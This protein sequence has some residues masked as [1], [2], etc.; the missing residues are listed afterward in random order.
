MLPSH[1]VI[2]MIMQP[3]LIGII[4]DEVV[5]L[6]ASM[7]WKH[8]DVKNNVREKA[9]LARKDGTLPKYQLSLSSPPPPPPSSSPVG[10]SQLG[11]SH[12]RVSG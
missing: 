2:S 6:P 11:K 12:Q 7:V 3:Y 1:I 4:F 10:V 5:T 8:H 9:A